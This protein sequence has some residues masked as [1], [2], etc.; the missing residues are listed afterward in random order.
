VFKPE[1]ARFTSAI[2]LAQELVPPPLQ[3]PQPQRS[4]L[5]ALFSRRGHQPKP[6][7]LRMVPHCT[8]KSWWTPMYI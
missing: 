3:P 6:L 5:A 7:L 4:R 2:T 8:P 1:E